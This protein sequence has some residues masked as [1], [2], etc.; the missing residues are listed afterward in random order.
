MSA[1][2]NS[3]WLPYGNSE[4]WRYRSN[5]KK[6]QENNKL[7]ILYHIFNNVIVKIEQWY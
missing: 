4:Q 3:D 5:K 1:R 6:M 2:L 7:C